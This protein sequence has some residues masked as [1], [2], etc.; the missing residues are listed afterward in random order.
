MKASTPLMWSYIGHTLW[1]VPICLCVCACYLRQLLTQLRA[2]GPWHQCG[3]RGAK[4]WR[5]V[6]RV[7]I[8]GLLEGSLSFSHSYL[9]SLLLSRSL[10]LFFPSPTKCM[11]SWL[12]NSVYMWLVVWDVFCLRCHIFTVIIWGVWLSITLFKNWHSWGELQTVSVTQQ[13][14]SLQK[15]CTN[16]FQINSWQGWTNR[17][18]DWWLHVIFKNKWKTCSEKNKQFLY[19]WAKINMELDLGLFWEFL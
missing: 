10:L 1:N 4:F 7:L 6:Q 15:H 12:C 2:G 5:R 9:I 19:L 13:W 18:E 16:Q 17:K 3:W 14:L 11:Q 8:P